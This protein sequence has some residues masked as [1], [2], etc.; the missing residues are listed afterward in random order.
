MAITFPALPWT[1]GQTFTA[2]NGVTYTYDA[3]AG[4]WTAAASGG[5]S[6]TAATL[7][8]A[9][10]GVINN[11]YLSPETGIAKNASGT[12]G[13]ALLPAGTTTQRAAITAPVAGMT[14]YNSTIGTL[15]VYD[16]T[17]WIA[18]VTD[19]GGVDPFGWFGHSSSPD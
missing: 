8:E 18:L 14:R 7:A 1:G 5:S 12:T 10:A 19:S 2:T 16:G 4:A 15:E 13:A 17:K 3:T 9:A 11:K 6:V